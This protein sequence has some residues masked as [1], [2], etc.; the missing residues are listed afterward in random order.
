MFQMYGWNFEIDHCFSTHSTM[1][2]NCNYPTAIMDQSVY[3]GLNLARIPPVIEHSW[4]P[5]AFGHYQP[6]DLHVA[7]LPSL[8][9]PWYDDEWPIL[10]TT[11]ASTDDVWGYLRCNDY[12][13]IPFRI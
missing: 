12:F 8:S 4:A 5:K 10:V 3:N 11:V 7:E 1:Q 9:L 2:Q 13:V 6:N